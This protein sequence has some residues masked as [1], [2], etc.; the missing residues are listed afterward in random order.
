M[1]AGAKLQEVAGAEVDKAN[2]RADAHCDAVAEHIS[3]GL[4]ALED[5]AAAGAQGCTTGDTGQH[6]LRKRMSV[7]ELYR[8]SRRHAHHACGV[9]HGGQA[10][11]MEGEKRQQAGVSLFLA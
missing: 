8:G 1:A 11:L 2:A 7:I 3:Y 10:E 6:L 9:Y 4:S 5:A